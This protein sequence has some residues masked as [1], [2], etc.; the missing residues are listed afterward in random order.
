MSNAVHLEA[1]LAANG[2][3]ASRSG[4]LVS[5]IVQ[6]AAAIAA[7]TLI[8][9]SAHAG[10]APD[11]VV[12][13]DPSLR[14]AM[15]DAGRIW[16][17]RTRVP[18][19]VFR[20]SLGQS[21]RLSSLGARADVLIGIG[22]D[23]MD[24]AQHLGAIDPATRIMIGRDPVVLARRGRTVEPVTLAPGLDIEPLLGDGRIGLVDLAIG[25]P[26]ADARAA[27]SSV[28]LWPALEPRSSGAE[29]TDALAAQLL[30]GRVRLAAIYRS[31]VTVS[32][33][34]SVAAKFAVAAPLVVAA[35]AVNATSPNAPEFLE[36]LLGDGSH[37]LRSA[38]LDAP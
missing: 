1:G 31:D 38:G 36:F 5:K 22:P 16:S 7:G 10:P 2:S 15:V 32:S 24:I 17:A 18:V 23:Q 19:R 14:A 26:G 35:L 27:L 13:S 37:S 28:G 6:L 30:E 12:L 4:S 25:K 29:D 21:A 34:F 9:R 3:D 33:G 20:A 11:V 8:A